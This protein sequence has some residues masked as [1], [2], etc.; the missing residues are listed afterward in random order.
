MDTLFAERLLD[1]ALRRGADEAEVYLKRSKSLGIDVR[2]QKIDTLETSVTAGFCLRVIRDRRLGF[3][4]STAPD[5]AELVVERALEASRHTE[6]DDALALPVR[7]GPAPDLRVFDEAVPA[8][9]ESEAI[10]RVM[11]VEKTALDTD[12]RIRK[13]RKASG[14]FGTSDTYILNSHGVDVRYASSGCSAQLMVIAEEDGESQMG[15]DYEGSRFLSGVQFELVGR[16]AAQNALRL[17][18]ARKT[19]AVRGFV[20]LDSS[21]TTEFLGIFAAALSSESVQKKKSMLA[22]KKGAQVISTRLTV[23]DSGM[24]EGRLGSRP[25]DDE[26]VPTTSKRLIDSG[27]LTGYLY[28][29]YTARKDNVASTGNAVRG[30]ALS[31]PHVGPTCLVLESSSPERVAGFDRLVRAADRGLYVLETM[32]MHTANPVSGEF[33]VGASGVWIENG[34]LRY[35]VKEAVISGTVLDLFQRVAA[36]GDDMRFYGNIGASSL[37]IEDIDIS[38]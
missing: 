30:G 10:E 4:Y 21:V 23:T 27:V 26:G 1:S 11:L 6:P 36:V 34:E 16:R 19:T 37:L 29:T 14:H 24:I 32:G 31:L 22:G 8:L 20:L 25:F 15:W 28:N 13:V 5:D 17:L 2:D 7:S 3:S 12:S 35:P 33:S 38:A 9:P 18:G